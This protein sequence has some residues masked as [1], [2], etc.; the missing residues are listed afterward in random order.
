MKLCPLF[1]KQQSNGEAVSIFTIDLKTSR[2]EH[3]ETAKAAHK[4]IKTLRHPN[5]LTYV[6]GLEVSCLTF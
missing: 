3:I 5:F 1:L 4:R 6:D 2:S